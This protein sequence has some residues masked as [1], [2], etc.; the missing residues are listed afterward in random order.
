MLTFLKHHG[1]PGQ[2][3][4][5]RRGPP[6]PIE[7][8][9]LKKG[10]RVN[11][12]SLYSNPESYRK[13]KQWMYTYNPDDKWDSKVYK[14]PFAAY[15][16]DFARRKLYEHRYE[17]VA[18][19]KMPTSK[20]RFDAF[21]ELYN[22][23]VKTMTKDLK[24]VLLFTPPEISKREGTNDIDWSKIATDE[25]EQ[26][27][28]YKAFN[29]AMEYVQAFKSTKSYA[30]M[31]AA[32]F[33][34]MVDDNNQGVYND[35]NDPVIFFNPSKVLKTIGETTIVSLDEMRNNYNEVYYEL[36]KKGKQILL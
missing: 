1:I 21:V 12:V 11:S 23:D 10:H 5:V 20:E 30:K 19:L 24:R 25:K 2:K 16:T 32:K 18:D 15:K 28:A 22:K 35:T 29:H 7:D 13:R 27:K 9:V 34:A 26:K 8:K 36:E 17:V 31:M 4:G 33:D 3:W 14:G 6:Y